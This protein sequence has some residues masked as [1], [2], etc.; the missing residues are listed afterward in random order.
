[1]D[2]TE[3]EQVALQQLQEDIA[4]H[5]S[6][7]V[8]TAMAAPE[9][10]RP[11]QPQPQQEK[12]RPL[13]FN[14]DYMLLWSGQ[15]ISAVGSGMSGIVFPLLILAI[16]VSASNPTG[17]TALAGFAAA[18]GSLP[19]LL[20]S[21]PVGALIDRWNRKHVMIICDTFRALNIASIPLAFALD[22]ITPWQLLINAFIEGIFFVFFN[23]A[24]VA[25][26][27]RVVPKKQLPQA[28]AQ[29]EG[30]FIAA[31]LAGPPI[32]TFL[33]QSVSRAFPFILDAVSYA[34]SVVSLLFIKTQFQGER[35]AE[36]RHILVE[37][38]EGLSWL[39]NQPLIRFMAFLTGGLNF[40]NAATFLILIVRAKDLGASDTEIGFL[41]SIGALGGVV[42]A[43]VGGQIQKRFSF[44]QVII[45]TGW[46]NVVLY[47]TLL[48]APNFLVLG[49][50]MGLSWMTG[51]IY[52]VVQFSY[53]LALIPDKLQGRVNST[54][55]LLAY[56]FQPIGAALSGI[57]L[58]VFGTTGTIIAYG[59]VYVV[60]SLATTINSYVRNAKPL[61]QVAADAH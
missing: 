24:E 52:N 6:V 51:P 27:P 43:V 19:Y 56:G 13:V 31:N 34:F 35:P 33:F 32:G 1:M 21:L 17:D 25:A 41:V 20:I 16:T 7:S 30:G 9:N 37:I 48:A 49:I 53:R 26:L 11:E 36:Q 4:I 8:D 22:K 55:R 23:I 54:F 5:S 15:V 57:L 40:I 14:R 10:A 2:T 59:S 29:N 18:L 61:E 60:L 47:F 39:W 42:G 28:T 45:T 58:G 12:F 50:I 3:Q 46:I 44:A 38:R